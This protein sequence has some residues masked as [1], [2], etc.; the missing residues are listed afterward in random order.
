MENKRKSI[1]S[2]EMKKNDL[3]IEVMQRMVELEFDV[4]DAETFPTF[5]A[6]F[7]R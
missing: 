4:E 1:I 6:A 3:A 2:T 5:H 7:S